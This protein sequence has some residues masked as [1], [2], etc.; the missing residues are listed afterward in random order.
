MEMEDTE[1][2]TA[3]RY[4]DWQAVKKALENGCDPD[5]IG[6]YEWSPLHEACH[7]GDINIVKLLL[8]HN[9]KY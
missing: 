3:V 5:Q 2:H 9:G 7:N 4:G 6:L 8:S 1:L